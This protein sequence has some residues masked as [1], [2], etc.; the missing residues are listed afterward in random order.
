MGFGVLILPLAGQMRLEHLVGP[1]QMP[2][3]G[4][5]PRYLG[6]EKASGGVGIGN[7]VYMAAASPKVQCIESGEINISA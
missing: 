4:Y 3:G 1:L 2:V 6:R 7:F 5:Q